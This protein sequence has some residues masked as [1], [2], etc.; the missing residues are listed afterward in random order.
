MRVSRERETPIA[1]HKPINSRQ[2]DP[3]REKDTD[4]SH[5]ERERERE[6]E[7]AQSIDLSKELEEFGF[8]QNQEIKRV[9]QSKKEKKALQPVVVVSVAMSKGV[10]LE[11]FRHEHVLEEREEA[12]G[13]RREIEEALR[14]F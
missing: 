4:L 12:L 6:R 3:L 9:G 11:A 5:R 7:R 10:E 2:R 14:T 8:E 13:F 1:S